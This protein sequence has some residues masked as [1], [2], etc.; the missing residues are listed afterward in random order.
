MRGLLRALLT[1]TWLYLI[2]GISYADTPPVIAQ[3]QD[4]S[5]K[6][7]VT[8]LKFPNGS[9]SKSGT[10]YTLGLLDWIVTGTLTGAQVTTTAGDLPQI[11]FITAQASDTRYTIGVNT[12][13]GNDDDDNLEVVEGLALG[14][15]VRLKLDTSGNL[16]IG[17]NPTSSK[18]AVG[19]VIESTTG[20]VK[21][22]DGVT[23]TVALT[24]APGVSRSGTVVS[25]TTSTDT[26]V[27]GTVASPSEKVEIGGNLKATEVIAGFSDD[28][29][30]DYSPQQIND[31]K[32]SAG[33][34]SDGGNDDDDVFEIREGVTAGTTPRISIDTSGEIT[35]HSVSGDG[36]GKAICI[37]ADGKLGTCSDA[38]GGSG[39]CTCA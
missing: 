12:D 5:P 28:P 7:L 17:T 9:L 29:Q 2:S 39:T 25:L 6:G 32:Y 16:G 26:M 36:S 34:N 4:G 10:A 38:V 21:Y 30:T 23:Q 24:A 33:T 27:L 19:G 3:E 15:N 20:G 11:Q 22:P 1:Y 18:I 37:K 14:T 35:L 8:T 31:T 13:G